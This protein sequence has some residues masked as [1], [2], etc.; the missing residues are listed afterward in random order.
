[1]NSR[2]PY[3]LVSR[4]WKNSDTVFEVNGTKIGQDLVMIAGPCAVENQEQIS[5]ITEYLAKLNVKFIRGG[6]YK[7]RTS[8]YSFQGLKTEGLKLLRDAA[9]KH[10]LGVVSEVMSED[11]IA[12]LEEYTDILQV[13]SLA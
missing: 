3:Q 6:A 5:T 2:K 7:P 10:G 11:K 12:E 13:G 1:M 8:P 4:E 9:D